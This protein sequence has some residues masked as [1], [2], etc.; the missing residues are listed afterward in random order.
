MNTNNFEFMNKYILLERRL[1]KH[2]TTVMEYAKTLSKEDA[3]KLTVIRKYR[4]CLA[5]NCLDS[6]TDKVDLQDWMS[7]LDTL[8]TK[9]TEHKENNMYKNFNEYL[10]SKFGQDEA[11][12]MTDNY[13]ESVVPIDDSE[14]NRI[15]VFYTGEALSLSIYYGEFEPKHRKAIYAFI[16]TYN[17]REDRVY[18]LR[19][20]NDQ[21]WIEIDE[22]EVDDQRAIEIIENV[23][24]YFTQENEVVTKLQEIKS[25]AKVRSKLVH[26]Y[27]LELK[28]RACLFENEGRHDVA[29]DIYNYIC[30]LFYGYGHM[31]LIALHYGHGKDTPWGKLPLNKEYQLECQMLAVRKSKGKSSILAPM[32]AYNVAKRLGKDDLCDEIIAIGQERGTWNLMA[33]H[34]N[35]D[36][37]PSEELKRISDCYRKGIGCDRSEEYARYYDRLLA[38]ERQ[39]VFKDMLLSGFEPVF[40]L[41]SP[42]V[43]F[44]IHSLDD[45]DGL[46]DEFKNRFLYGDATREFN[47]PEWFVPMVNALSE[48]EREV[49]L[50]HAQSK[51][52]SS[53]DD[54]LQKV[55]SGEFEI[56]E[57]WDSHRGALIEDGEDLRYVYLPDLKELKTTPAAEQLKN[58]LEDFTKNV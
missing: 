45:L 5:H 47:L 12:F 50:K 56:I 27:V 18:E 51:L 42:Y 36:V 23:I 32:V 15:V 33:L 29:M 40:E 4:N 13:V 31:E 19:Y 46:T 10:V 24:Q 7:F 41:M 43:H 35:A 38:G 53:I 39:E 14:S 8:I 57:N 30:D 49:V 1:W 52:K 48:S 3:C 44:E 2:K 34:R 16:D 28:K 26:D 20:M 11:E 6:F 17:E 22:S 21:I 37:D 9:S 58:M 25:S 54:F 55:K